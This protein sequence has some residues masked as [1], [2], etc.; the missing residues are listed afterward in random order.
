MGHGMAP[1]TTDDPIL[2]AKTVAQFMAA[3]NQVYGWHLPTSFPPDTTLAQLWALSVVV[4]KNPLPAVLYQATT[5]AFTFA[6]ILSGPVV[7]EI[8]APA[9]V[10]GHNLP[11]DVNP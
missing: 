6:P 4:Q 8:P 7:A 10:P 11:Q 2:D 5:P 1:G 9:A 3:A